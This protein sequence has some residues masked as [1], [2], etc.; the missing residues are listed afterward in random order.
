MAAMG[1][2]I[3]PKLQELKPVLKQR[4][5][6]NSLELF[7]SYSR[8]EQTK[9]SDIDLLVDFTREADLFDLMGLAQ[10]LEKELKCKVDVI[11]KNALRQELRKTV[12]REAVPV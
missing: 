5:K 11:P 9:E 3:L 10:Y 6:I 4:F 12:F 7:G 2:D 1:K 8:G